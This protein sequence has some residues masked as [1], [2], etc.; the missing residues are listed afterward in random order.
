MLD[1]LGLTPALAWLLKEVGRSSGFQT[2]SNIDPSLDTLP[3]AHRTCVYRVVQEALTNASRHS[4]A[5]RVE[6]TLT[7]LGGWV[8]GS[9]VDDGSG[10]Q[11]SAQKT[12]GLGLLGME[13]RVRELGGSIHIDSSPRGGTSLRF[14]LPCPTLTEVAD[15]TDSDRGRSRD[16]SDRIETSA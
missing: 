6:V 13:E 16:R 4:G 3:E 10:F 2:P 5:R 8:T 1:D 9:I 11:K 12:P 14:H 15:D 7:S